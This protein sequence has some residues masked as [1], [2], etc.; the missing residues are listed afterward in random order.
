[1]MMI[2]L[3]SSTGTL[4]SRGNRWLARSVASARRRPA[5]RP[6]RRR[7][8]WPASSPRAPRTNRDRGVRLFTLQ[9]SALGATRQLLVAMFAAVMLFLLIACANVIDLSSSVRHPGAA[10][11]RC[12]C[13]RR[14]PC[15][16]VQQLLAE[17]LTLAAMGA[18]AGDDARRLGTRRALAAPARRCLPGYA[19]PSVEA[20][21]LGSRRCSRSF[22]GSCS[23]WRPRIG[24]A[25]PRR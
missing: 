15:W 4:E 16:V 5:E 13:R 2:S 17:G 9:D 3:T 18:I 23:G 24:S 25:A 1:M 21:V 19:T 12:A 11:W 14:R 10:R 7:R 20:G 6:A 8:A 22:A